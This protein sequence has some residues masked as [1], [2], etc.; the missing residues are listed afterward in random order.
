MNR[1][2]R[3]ALL[4]LLLLCVFAGG[5]CRS[6]LKRYEFNEPKMGAGFR[7]VLYARSDAAADRAAR[8]TFNRVDA[9]SEILNDY[10]PDSE[11]SRLSQHTLNG[12]MLEPV[13]VSPELF[14]ILQQAYDVADKTG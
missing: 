6:S 5:G 10:D 2:I 7:I 11:I 14:F 3:P 8:A 9:L 13:R 1:L 4:S 12:P